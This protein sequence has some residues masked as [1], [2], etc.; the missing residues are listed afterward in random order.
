MTEVLVVKCDKLNVR[1]EPSTS[2]S[3]ST[4]VSVGEHLEIVE[5]EKDGWY[6]ASING[7]TGYV[8]ADYVEVVYSL[9]TASGTVIGGVKTGTNNT[10]TSGVISVA[11]AS[12]SAKGVVQ[13]TDG[14]T[15]TSTTTAATAK[16]VATALTSAKTYSDTNLATAKAYTD[17]VFSNLT[18]GALPETL[19]TLKEIAA[20]VED[21]ADLIEAM[22]D[23]V[24]N[25]GTITSTDIDTL[26]T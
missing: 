14:T 17:T 11:N 26:F 2:C 5:G 16:S 6:K 19:D 18:G 25:I 23:A 9:P 10:N 4:K 8:S 21:N 20:A 24:T 15:S 3:I 12:T 22:Q 1:E 7:L 13:L